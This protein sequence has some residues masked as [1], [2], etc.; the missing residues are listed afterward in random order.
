MKKLA[1][2][3]QVEQNTTIVYTLRYPLITQMR[4]LQVNYQNSQFIGNH[5]S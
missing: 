1:E 3:T 4:K 2:S 5:V